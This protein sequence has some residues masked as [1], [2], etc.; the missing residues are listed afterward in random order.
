M[1][2]RVFAIIASLACS[3]AALAAAERATFILT[4]GERKSGQIAFHGS[5]RENVINGQVAVG[6]DTGGPEFNFPLSQVA[7]IDFVGGTPPQSELAAVPP[8]GHFM[9]L[10]SGQSQG[11]TFV[12]IVDGTTLIWKN[13]SGE[14]QRYNVSD[15]KRVYLN[16]E[17]ART[18][19]NYTGPSATANAVGTSGQMATQ[20]GPIQVQVQATQAWNDGGIT[21]KKGDRL[22]FSTTGQIT[23]GPNAGMTAGPQGSDMFRKQTYPVPNVP[24]GALIGRV[25]TGAPFAIGVIPDPIPMPAD[26]RLMLGVNDDELSDNSGA[27]TVTV[28]KIG[29]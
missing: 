22:Q 17:S 20:G 29:Q 19:F 28:T 4:D 3:L 12:N 11:G 15:V 23:F 7:L 13:T 18:V 1:R 10:K 26:G 5:D 24:V 27:F 2:S 8:S 21:V 6:N 14:T 9:T 25:G 16:P